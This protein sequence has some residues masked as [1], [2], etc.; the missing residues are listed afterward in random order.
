MRHALYGNNALTLVHLDRAIVPAK[1][2]PGA[3]FVQ[4]LAHRW[5][6]VGMAALMGSSAAYGV[7]ALAHL[8]L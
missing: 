4:W 1:P 5:D 8:G 7:Y 2:K 3:G 6:M